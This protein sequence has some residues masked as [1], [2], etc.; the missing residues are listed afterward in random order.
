MP[1]LT[2]FVTSFADDSTLELS[3]NLEIL[4]NNFNYELGKE[5]NWFQANRLT[6]DAK[7][8]KCMVLGPNGNS[9]PLPKNLNCRRSY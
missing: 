6:L 1:R 4:I 3:H 7:K 9:I 8:T 2:N 5:A